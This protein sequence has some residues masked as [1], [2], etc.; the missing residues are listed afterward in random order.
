M[1]KSETMKKTKQIIDNHK[2]NTILEKRLTRLENLMKYEQDAK[3]PVKN[4]STEDEVFNAAAQWARDYIDQLDEDD[5]WVHRAGS[6]R[7]VL[8][9][10]AD[11]S[12]DPIVDMCCVDIEHEY[13]FT[14]SDND[15]DI[16]ASA[17]ASEAADAMRYTIDDDWDED[18]EDFES[19]RRKSRK[20]I[21]HEST[22]KLAKR[23]FIS[24]FRK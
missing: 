21:K 8:E 11:E 17:I 20:P 5:Y 7:K 19:C 12:A 14:L 18:E 9:L 23:S 3:R 1:T 16:V 22:K 10:M 2:R 13:E 6:L 15:R 24:R 4:E